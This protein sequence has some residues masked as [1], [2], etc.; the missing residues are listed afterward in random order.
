MVWRLFNWLGLPKNPSK[1]DV[2]LW[3]KRASDLLGS[4]A[5]G[6]GGDGT[7]VG[8]G[9]LPAEAADRAL[10]ASSRPGGNSS[11]HAVAAIEGSATPE[12]GGALMGLGGGVDGG[13][14]TSA[15]SSGATF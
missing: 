10:R 13:I 12:F 2:S 6:M 7:R 14:L 15:G 8:V 9:G 3:W 5:S 11:A 4:T 1:T